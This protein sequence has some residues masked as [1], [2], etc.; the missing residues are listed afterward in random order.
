MKLNKF[1]YKI[2]HCDKHSK[3]KCS[4]LE[5]PH[6]I[7]E[8][9]SFLFCA[10]RGALK[11]ITMQQAKDSGATALI[12]NTYHLLMKNG[13]DIA[14]KMGGIHNM[15]Q[16]DGPVFT[17]SGGYQIFSMGYGSVSEEI[18]S[19]KQLNKNNIKPTLIKIEESGALFKSYVNGSKYLLS[20]ER[21]MEIQCQLGSDIVLVLDECTPFNTSKE[22]TEKSMYRSHRWSKRSLEFF[23]NYS[24]KYNQKIYGI[25]QGGIYSDLRQISAKFISNM[26]FFGQAIGG[27]L[28]QNKAQMI[29]VI[30]VTTNNLNL[31]NRPTH[32]LG[33]GKIEDIFNTVIYGID[34]F[35]CVY[36]TRLARHGCILVKPRDNNGKE[37]INLKNSIYKTDHSSLDNYNLNC[38]SSNFSKSYINYLFKCNETLAGNLL[39]IYNISFISNMF[40]QIRSAIKNNCLNDLRIQYL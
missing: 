36:P 7:I 17:D 15:M 38:Y 24:K 9:P 30:K 39:T 31:H 11:G 35:D 23:Y 33:I 22:Y 40:A 4:Y 1:N 16:W 29:E 18:K 3:A 37:Y 13:L 20:P 32:L 6:G 2:I 28:G 26:P 25:V 12:S 19:N 10:T 21:S 34:T 5:T 14:N 27:T 8:T